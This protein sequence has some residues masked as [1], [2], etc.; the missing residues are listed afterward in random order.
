MVTPAIGWL[1]QDAKVALSSTA[2]LQF[3]LTTSGVD[4]ITEHRLGQ[5]NFEQQTKVAALG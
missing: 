5:N 1:L 3:S 4:Y 2:S